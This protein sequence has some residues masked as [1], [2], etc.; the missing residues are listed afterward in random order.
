MSATE[1]QKQDVLDAYGSLPLSFIP[2]N[3]H[4][5]SRVQYYSHSGH[6][7]HFAPDEVRFT[8]LE[9]NSRNDMHTV[10]KTRNRAVRE[11]SIRGMVLSLHFIHANPDVTLV[12]QQEGTGKVNYFIGHDPAKWVTNLPTYHEI[13][14]REL[15][16]GVDLLIGGENGELKYT[17][18][19]QPGTDPETIR[20]EYL[21]A[22]EV[23]LDAEGNLQIHTR[24]G[25]LTDNSPSSYQEIN[26]HRVEV[27]SS[28]VLKQNENEGLYYG[29]KI[30]DEYDSHYP[31]IIDPGLVYSTY[32]GGSGDDS[33]I[34]IAV[35]ASGNAYVTGT[36][37]STDFPVTPGAFQTTFAGV[38]DAFVTKL[39]TTGTA[40]I[41]S[42]YL[43]GS[44]DDEGFSLAI[45]ASG[46]AYVT[47]FTNSSDFPVTAGAFQTTFAG[48]EDV[49]VTKLNATGTA[50]VYS[51]YLGG[52]GDDE[53]FGVAVD[54]SGNAYVT[55]VTNSTNFPVTAGAFSTV[56][57]GGLFDSFVTK[58]NPAG[59]ALVYSTYLG[60]SNIDE[61]LSI[62]VDAA[63]DA[64]VTGLTNSTNFPVTPGAFQSAFAG[65]IDVFVTKLNASGTALV[66]STYLGGSGDD[67]GIFIVLDGHGNA[68]VTGL[69]DS[70]NF[71]A[72]PG[73]FST[74][75]NG[76][77]D[78]AFVTKLNAT[79]TALV[80]STYLGGSGDD[81]GFGIAVDRI[82]NAY[83]AG[84]TDSANF[85]VTP[86]AFSPLYNGGT[87]DGFVSKLS[88]AGTALAYSTYL[89]GAG[90]DSAN[91]IS[92][93]IAENA[94]VVGRTDSLNFPTTPGA[95]QTA[96]AGGND[97]FVTKIQTPPS[98]LSFSTGVIQ[99]QTP[100]DPIASTIH[101]L[102]S[103]DNTSSSSNAEIEV[104]YVSGSNKIPYVHELFSIAPVTVV[105][106]SYFA[107]FK[108]F[109]IQY[110]ITG[111]T[112]T[113]VV[114]SI[115]PTDAQGNAVAAQRVLQTE[116]TAIS[117][118]TPVP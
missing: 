44:G 31:L 65:I 87:S 63:G 73:A 57:N 49:F 75:F 99:N 116:A 20:L 108:A 47:G 72:T 109:E 25:V 3:G 67:E 38:E 77:A 52:V 17:F 12:G 93:D 105:T 48:L 6:G 4:I 69:T 32:L 37:N 79:G 115:F 40:L 21:G 41:Y 23:S 104:F 33:G 9:N 53:G 24:Y 84:F 10:R 34:S 60:G 30:G 28:F 112:P 56:Y 94:Y 42:T 97:A 114:S 50:L 103:N 15:W 107:A 7:I 70:T 98:V 54:I 91:G 100:S 45:D 55:G 27:S 117:S 101:I 110:A 85:P 90:A 113:D 83:V 74:T 39:N 58:L 59:T 5:D 111:A 2:N 18:I 29:F 64:Y 68:Y 13:A 61:G 88:P 19:L 62:A 76:G 8:F 82:G 86:D 14:Y 81:E 106:R 71:P 96:L 118:I 36:T 51:T 89:G 26:G 46:N 80:Y 35:D 1:V 43:G 66:Y 16:N 92:V 22:D 102:I 11:N 95:F 78:D